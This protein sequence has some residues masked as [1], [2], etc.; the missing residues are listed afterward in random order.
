MLVQRWPWSKAIHQ[1]TTV[2]FDRFNL[3]ALLARLEEEPCI[4]SR[5]ANQRSQNVATQRI[6]TL[7]NGPERPR[8]SSCA[9]PL[10]GVFEGRGA[11]VNPSVVGSNA[12]GPTNQTNGLGDPPRPAI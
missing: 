12:R 5:Y 6:R 4:H 3:G 1:N 9:C 7:L 2:L 10:P 11:A 8:F